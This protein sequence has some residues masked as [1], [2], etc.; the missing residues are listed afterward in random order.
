MNSKTDFPLSGVR[1]WISGSVPAELSPKEADR[2]QALAKTLAQMAFR[3]GATLLHGFHPSL[4]PTLLAAAR[5]YRE[6]TGNRASLSLLASTE[7]RDPDGGYAGLSGAEVGRDADLQ[8]IPKGV[9]RKSSLDRLRDNLAAQADVL[10]AF[11]GKWWIEA[12]HMAGTPA[13]FLLA[14]TRGIPAFL[15]GGLGGATGGYLKKH[16]EILRQLRNGLDEAANVALAADGADVEAIAGKIME[17]IARLPLGRRETDSGQRFRILALDGGGIRGVF[18]AAVL[19]QWEDVSNL[20]AAD[21]FDLIAG[22]STG[23]ILAIGLGL[24]LSARSIVEFYRDQG[25]QIFPMTSA[26]KSTWHE[27]KSWLSN[28]FDSAGLEECLKIAYYKAAKDATLG[29]SRQR[30][31]ITSYNL[32]TNDICLYRTSHHPSVIGHDSLPAVVVARATSAAPTYFEVAK[33]AAGITEHAAVDGGVWANCPALAAVS[34][35]V[36]VLKIPLERIDVLSIGTASLPALIDNP[37]L[38]GKIGWASRAPDLLMNA[39]LD[40]TLFYLKELLGDRFVRIDDGKACVEEL[41]SLK[42]LE[43]LIGRGVLAG[44][45]NANAVRARFINGVVAAPWREL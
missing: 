37:D 36:N 30:L 28:K 6:A 29:N 35:A 25:P 7:F 10:V 16:P 18:T 39:Q 1:I 17:Q 15:L 21:H 40:A 44:A 9:D 3:E 42:F 4:T 38:Q 41:D 12:P 23:G 14:I 19:A 5:G 13:E 43:L 2:L 26:A 11:G 27:V 34:E 32:T 33:V 22:T 8:E 45:E 31:L 20:R 24:G